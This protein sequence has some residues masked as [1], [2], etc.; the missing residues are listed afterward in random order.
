MPTWCCSTVSATTKSTA[1]GAN[2]AYATHRYG[3]RTEGADG[4]IEILVGHSLPPGALGPGDSPSPPGPQPSRNRRPASL[5]S[6]ASFRSAAAPRALLSVD[7]GDRTVRRRRCRRRRRRHHSVI[8]IRPARACG[9][10]SPASSQSLRRQRRPLPSVDRGDKRSMARQRPCRR[11]NR[12]RPAS[13]LVVSCQTSP[14]RVQNWR[15]W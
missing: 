6:A 14:L 11:H 7:R 12:T 3:P 10:R 1:N 13:T 2:D 4:G 5:L 9:L 15:I 8:R